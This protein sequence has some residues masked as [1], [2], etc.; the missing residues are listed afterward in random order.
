LKIADK[1]VFF[2]FLS[3]F[4][5]SYQDLDIDGVDDSIDKCLNTPFDEIVDEN[6]CSKT[7]KKSYPHPYYGNLTLK[8]G[9]DYYKDK[10]YGDESSLNL[11]ADY[12]FHNWDFSISNANSNFKDSY[13]D[14][15]VYLFAG[16]GFD[17]KI[18]YIRLSIGTKLNKDT[19]TPRRQ[20]DYSSYQEKELSINNDYIFSIDFSHIINDKINSLL[21]YKYTINGYNDE[22]S[23]N[24][25]SFSV[26]IEYLVN[27]KC[28]SSLSYNQIGSMY[29]DINTPNKNIEISANYDITKNIFMSAEYGHGLDDLSY[30]NRFYLGIGVNF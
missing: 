19:T 11:Y 18:N 28:Y 20:K 15:D 2:V 22:N 23:K 9:L 25:S 1:I 7:Q 30:D 27:S 4:A 3:T 12:Q 14:N 29:K 8:I 21:Y 26:G 13:N 6:G 17:F 24:F 5:L 16:Y 10:D